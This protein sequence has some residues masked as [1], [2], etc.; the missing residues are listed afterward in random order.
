MQTISDHRKRIAYLRETLDTLVARHRKLFD[1]RSQSWHE[2]LEGDP[3]RQEKL[4]ELHR[5]IAEVEV[6]IEYMKGGLN[7]IEPSGALPS[8]PADPPESE[9][10]EAANGDRAE[11][12]GSDSAEDAPADAASGDPSSVS[13]DATAEGPDSGSGELPADPEGEPPVGSA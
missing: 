5:E 2:Q 1:L 12:A 10:P 9:P 11:T 4:D 13:D 3:D 6:Q 7:A 8:Q